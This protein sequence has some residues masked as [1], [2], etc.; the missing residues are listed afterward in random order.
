MLNTSEILANFDS[1][2]SYMYDYIS[3]TPKL[4]FALDVG[5]Y[6]NIYA[7]IF[8]TDDKDYG[9]HIYATKG[10][11]IESQYIDVD[12]GNIL[13]GA[14]LSITYAPAKHEGSFVVPLTSPLKSVKNYWAFTK[15]DGK[16]TLAWQKSEYDLDN[17]TTKTVT[18]ADKNVSAALLFGS[19][20]NVATP[21]SSVVTSTVS[22]P[23][24][25]EAEQNVGFFARFFRFIFSWFK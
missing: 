12:K 23:M 9:K 10:K 13:T 19:T 20:Q 2:E 4:N 14:D 11:V 21:T 18:N 15:K 7:K 17:G 25:P 22:A 5:K 6:A 3:G 24:V 8:T 1:I 16:L